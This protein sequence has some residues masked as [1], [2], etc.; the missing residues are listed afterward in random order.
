[1]GKI[2][3]S[4]LVVLK[5]DLN[6]LVDIVC[7]VQVQAAQ[8]IVTNRSHDITLTAFGYVQIDDHLSTEH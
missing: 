8:W 2:G 5:I 4:C 6:N 7:L 1:V 3:G